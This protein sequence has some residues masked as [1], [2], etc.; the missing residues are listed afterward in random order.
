MF[1]AAILTISDKGSQ[2]KRVDESGPV[3]K[4]IIQSI[5]GNIVEYTVAPDEKVMISATLVQWAD[6]GNID[7]ILTNG[8]T[9]LSPRDYTPEATLAIID[10]MVPGLAEAMRIESL[11]KTPTGMLSRGVAGLRNRTLII[12]LPGSPQAV[13]ECLEAITPAI[14]HAIEV[15]RG[16][17]VECATR[18]Q[19]NKT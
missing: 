15:L 12:N 16:E 17:A 7:I 2:G 3:I 5:G 9:G 11:K 10:R 4:E 19:P 14:P 13:R 18:S 1:N 6:K 8:G